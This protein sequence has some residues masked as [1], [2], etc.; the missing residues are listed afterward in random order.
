LSFDWHF[1]DGHAGN[2]TYVS[3][4]YPQSG[5][6]TVQLTVTDDLEGVASTSQN[7]E[8]PEVTSTLHVADLDASTRTLFGSFWGDRVYINIRDAGGNPAV[9]ATVYGRFSD[10][11]LLFQC[12]TDS[13]GTCNVVAYLWTLDC[14]TF[15]VSDVVHSSLTYQPGDNWD[16]DGDS[17][18]T[19]ITACR[20]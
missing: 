18:G 16:P 9:N 19:S 6:Y 4:T 11:P 14:L 2:G 15:T 8:I 7:I 13:S 20:P 12:T 1:G 3:H 5:I 17:D 10:R